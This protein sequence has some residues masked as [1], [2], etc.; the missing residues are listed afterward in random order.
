MENATKAGNS[1][2]SIELILSMQS[3]LDLGENQEKLI[4]VERFEK[5][6]NSMFNN[7]NES[8]G[9]NSRFYWEFLA[10]YF[11]ELNDKNYDNVLAHLV[12]SAQDDKDVS[13]WLVQNESRVRS[14]CEWSSNYK[15]D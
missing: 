11:M 2:R 15:W 6:L 12:F 14:L 7:L 4:D 3:A 9:G 8:K 1:F 13:A 10:P 5:K